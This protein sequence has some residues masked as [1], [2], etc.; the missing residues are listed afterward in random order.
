MLMTCCFA[1]T[2]L[3]ELSISASMLYQL[4]WSSALEITLVQSG[5]EEKGYYIN[6]QLAVLR[7]ESKFW[8]VIQHSRTM[9][10][11]ASHNLLFSFSQSPF[12]PLDSCSLPWQI[13]FL[14]WIS[15]NLKCAGNANTRSCWRVKPSILLTLFKDPSL[16]DTLAVA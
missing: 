3:L 14:C 7:G 1:C 8:S 2:S 4:A 5:Q 12:L 10:Q 9:T 16:T 6:V 11:G 15:L 13:D